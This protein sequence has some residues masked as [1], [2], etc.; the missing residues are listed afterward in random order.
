MEARTKLV[1]VLQVAGCKG[2]VSGLRPAAQSRR[3]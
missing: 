1:E 2:F 3:R